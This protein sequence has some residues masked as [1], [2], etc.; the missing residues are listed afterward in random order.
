MTAVRFYFD[1]AVVEKWYRITYPK[2]GDKRR[3][4]LVECTG[5][6]EREAQHEGIA[7]YKHYRD[8]PLGEG[9]P[10]P[11]WLMWARL[12]L[13]AVLIAWA[14]WYTRPDPKAR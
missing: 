14:W 1:I 5:Y 4:V 3:K 13:Q 2:V 8:I 12:P 11:S 6:E 10:P 7:Y 9:P